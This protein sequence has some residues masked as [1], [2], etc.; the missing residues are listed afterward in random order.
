MGRMPNAEKGCHDCY[1]VLVK[2]VYW[3]LDEKSAW[4]A[5]TTIQATHGLGAAK[6]YNSGYAG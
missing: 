1:R 2:G 6:V 4:Y 3:Q 5:A